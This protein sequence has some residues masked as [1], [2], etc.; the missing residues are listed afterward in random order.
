MDASGA[1]PR[2]LL[3]ATRLATTSN[4]HVV[5]KT[6]SLLVLAGYNVSMVQSRLA[7]AAWACVLAVGACGDEGGTSKAAVCA[8]DPSEAVAP[9]ATSTTASALTMQDR[10]VVG[11]AAEYVPDRSLPAEEETLRTSMRARREMAWAVVARA[12]QPVALGEPRLAGQLGTQPTVPAW[13]TWYGKDDFERIFKKLYRA[14]PGQ[15]KA[16]RTP[17]AAEAIGQGVAWNAIALD[18]L[19]GSSWPE[20]RYLEYLASARTQQHAAGFAGISRVSYSPGALR[21]LLASYHRALACVAAGEPPAYAVDELAGG[22]A[23]TQHEQVELGA[24]GWQVLGPFVSAADAAVAVASVGTGD[25]DLYVR[26]GQAPTLNE[27]DCKSE[28]AT[29][30]EQCTVDGGG[31]IYVGVFAAKAGAAQIAVTYRE[32]DVRNPACLAGPMPPDAVLIKADWQRA[33]FGQQLPVFDTSGPRMAARLSPAGGFAWGPGDG[34]ADPSADKAY[35]VTLPNGNVFRLA[36]L[37]L[38]TKE[39]DHWVWITLWWSP[40]PDTDFGADR[41]AAIATLGGPW[42]NYK[43]CVATNFVEG[44]ADPRGGFAGSLGDALAA[45]HRGV[46]APTWCANPYLEQGDLNA[47]TNCIGCHQHGGTS[48]LVENILQQFPVSGSTR[49]RNNFFTDYLWALRGGRGEDIYA[50][51]KAEVDFWDATPP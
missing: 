38:M 50:T 30:A 26:R 1:Q 29:A 43:M 48:L 13:H 15:A 7:V 32:A 44:D 47:A 14:L 17:F 31:P 21:H 19:A 40:K 18:D 28:A 8:S 10:K 3:L 20:S 24:C 25:V 16:A 9:A 4:A 41:P 46:N 2:R 39:L 37:H 23:V 36:A 49:V 34:F 42:A 11:P 27:Y 12:L 51:V 22:R 45:T 35:T 5:S 6:I 33:Q